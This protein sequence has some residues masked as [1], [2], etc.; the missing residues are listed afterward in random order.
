MIAVSIDDASPVPP[1]EQ[2]RSQIAG[3]IRAGALEPGTAL[4]PIRQLAGDLGLAANTVAR[5]Y[6]AL[7]EEHLVVASGRRGTAVAHPGSAPPTA[8]EGLLTAAARR[9]LAEATRLGVGVDEALAA[10][11]RAAS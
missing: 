11:R 4:P 3:A 8:R 2:L 9:Y 10:A 6:K 5:A 1:F 7:E